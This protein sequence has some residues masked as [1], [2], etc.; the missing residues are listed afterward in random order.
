MTM[1]M[2]LRY[3]EVFHVGVAGAPITD[4]G[5]GPR[6]YIGR[7][8]RT[9]EANPDGYAKGDLVARAGDLRGRLLIHHGTNDRNA[10]LGNTMQFVRKA[11]DAGRPVDMMIYPDGVHVLE[12][13][14]AIHSLKTMLSYFLEHLRPEGWEPSRASLWR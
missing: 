4:L 12:G 11:I 5:N 9:P 14:D 7:I 3:P 10:V 1:M 6:Q 8:M 13:A 2:L